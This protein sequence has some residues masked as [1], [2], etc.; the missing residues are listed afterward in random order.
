[1]SDL[2]DF[3][4]VRIQ[5]ELDRF[6]RT[7]TI[8]HDLLEGV[9]TV[10]DVE[11]C[12][13]SFSKKYQNIAKRFLKTYKSD[14]SKNLKD[15]KHALR[16][17]Y[18]ATINTLNTKKHEYIFP[19]LQRKYRPGLNPVSVLYYEAREMLRSYDPTSHMHIWLHGLVTDNEYNNR[20]LDALTRDMRRLERVISRYYWPLTQLDDNIPLELFHARQMTKDFKHYYTFFTT[21]RYWEPEE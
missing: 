5:S 9:F 3:K 2:I 17:D 19:Q 11:D 7:K 8:P 16:K 12:L 18:T 6:N 15:L 20:I 10:A 13:P 4:C 1:M 21:V 14:I